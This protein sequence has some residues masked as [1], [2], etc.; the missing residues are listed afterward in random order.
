MPSILR[1]GDQ[2]RNLLHR[3]SN[4]VIHDEYSV[5][6]VADLSV[7]SESMQTAPVPA[8]KNREQ[9]PDLCM[10]GVPELGHQSDRTDTGCSEL[11]L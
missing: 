2:E 11:L 1:N 7:R 8:E 4:E 3:S 10:L 9:L 6:C 5:F